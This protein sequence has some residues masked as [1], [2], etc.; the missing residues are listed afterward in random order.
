MLEISIFRSLYFNIVTFK[1]N[2]YIYI[3]VRIYVCIY[4]YIYRSA[5]A[6]QTNG[7]NGLKF[8]EETLEYHGGSIS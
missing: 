3:D 2:K 6:G 8:F 1:V 7:P 5:I 4:I